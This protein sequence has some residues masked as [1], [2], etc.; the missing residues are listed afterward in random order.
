MKFSEMPYTR[1][2]F[3]AVIAQAQ[4]I[5]QRASSA[6]SGDRSGIYLA[7]GSR[8]NSLHHRPYPQGWRCE[9]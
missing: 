1:V 8:V 7:F 9:K 4:E 6:K 5:I 3:P 2:D